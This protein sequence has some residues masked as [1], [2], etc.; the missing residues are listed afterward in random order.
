MVL[1]FALHLFTDSRRF[2]ST[3]GDVIAWRYGPGRHERSDPEGFADWKL[4]PLGPNPWEP[5]PILIDQTLHVVQLAALGWL[6]T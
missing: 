6:L 1:L 4:R 5:L 3:L 2:R